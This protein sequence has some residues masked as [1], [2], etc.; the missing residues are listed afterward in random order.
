[1]R[2]YD[3][4]WE[5]GGLLRMPCLECGENFSAKRCDAKF[6]SSNCRKSWSRRKEQIGRDL[7]IALQSIESIRRVQRE[8]PDLDGECFMALTRLKA[9]LAVTPASVTDHLEIGET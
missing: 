7:S 2:R 6:C 8:R 1:M 3:Y 5:G 4:V 9:Q